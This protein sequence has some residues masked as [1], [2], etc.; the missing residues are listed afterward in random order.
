M[1]LNEKE[2][3]E[4]TKLNN[5]QLSMSSLVIDVEMRKERRK[6]DEGQQWSTD[7]HNTAL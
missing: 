3:R 2:R 1:L 4:R 7:T 6:D 5:Q